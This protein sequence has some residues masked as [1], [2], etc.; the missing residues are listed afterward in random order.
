MKIY[1]IWQ[2]VNN[3]YDVY[4]AAIVVAENEED[5]RMMTPNTYAGN[6]YYPY[7]VERR[8]GWGRELGTDWVYDIKDVNVEYIG[9]AKE[10]MPKGVVIGS[11]NAG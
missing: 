2:T 9:E 11:F 6:I 5:A 8:F 4:D 3:D 7:P 10:G 1:K